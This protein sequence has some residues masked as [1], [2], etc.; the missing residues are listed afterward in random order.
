VARSPGILP[1]DFASALRPF[2]DGTSVCRQRTGAHRARHPAG[3]LLRTLAAPQG[4]PFRR[5]PAAEATA[6]A[7]ACF[8]SRRTFTLR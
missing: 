4:V 6:T 3:F 5:H 7:R 2:A 1:S 8:A